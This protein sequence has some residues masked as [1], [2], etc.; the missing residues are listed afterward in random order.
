M[1]PG[2]PS[3]FRTDR[4][5]GALTPPISVYRVLSQVHTAVQISDTCRVALPRASIQKCTV[6][7]TFLHVEQ[8]KT[9]QN[10]V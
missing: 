3:V 10:G 7:M 8:M 9:A 5:G 4:G 1:M 2:G 6:C